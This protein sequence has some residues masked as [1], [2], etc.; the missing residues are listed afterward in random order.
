[1]SDLDM[2]TNR[3]I[4][5][6]VIDDDED[7]VNLFTEFLEIYN[8]SVIGK[9]FDGLQATDLYSKTLPDVVFSDVMMPEYDGFYVLEN[10]K[11]LNPDAIIIMITGDVRRDTIDKLEK[12]GADAILYK[13]FDMQVVINVVNNL[14]QKTST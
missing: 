7:T 1:M 8:V 12:L 3:T 6:L 4:N 5:A 11:K 14:L 13:P 10:I 9:A 2:P